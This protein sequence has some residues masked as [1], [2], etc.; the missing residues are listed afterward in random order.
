M[1]RTSIGLE[2]ALHDYLL[3]VSLRD[4]D[5]KARLRAETGERAWGCMQVAPE[6][7]Q[8][9]GFLMALLGAQ[10]VVE[11]GT[12]T[13]Y[14]TLCMAEAL[15]DTGRLVA[16]DIDAEAPAVGRRYWDE[17][18]VAG[19]I[20]L[21]I[22]PAAA[23]LDALLAEGAG[24]RFD[25][26]FID[27]DKENYDLY[28]ERCLDLV[29]PGGVILLDNVLWGGAVIDPAKTDAATEAI[30]ALNVKLHADARV[31]LSMLPLGDGLTLARK[32]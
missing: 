26:A 24:A 12:F 8:F 11:I 10:Q 16:C 22:A 2:T 14:S 6:Q 17:A 29:R 32:R 23:S 31:D 9:L 1:A 4:S 5:L 15:P 28:Y 27:A 7:G 13:G 21:R 30:R 3:A 25:L 19:R 18:G 20:E